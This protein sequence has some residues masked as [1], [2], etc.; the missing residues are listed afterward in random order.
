MSGVLEIVDANDYYPFGMNHLKTG[1]AFFGQ[2]SFKNFKFANKE[3]QEF[4]FY[5]FG[6]RLYMDDIV[7]WGVIDN[8]AEKYLSYS[9]YHY[10]GNNPISNFDIDG[11]EFTPEAWEYVKKL[12]AD[13]DN[14]QAKNNAEI[15]KY[16]AKI[17]GGGKERQIRSWERNVTNLQ[18]NNAELESARG[19]TAVL[20]GSN[21]M[22]DIRPDD[23]YSNKNESV[24]YTGFSFISGKIIIGLSKNAGMEL[25]SHELRHAYQFEIGELGF[26]TPELDKIGTQFL[27]DKTDEVDGYRRGSFFGGSTFGVNDLPEE[28]KNLPKGSINIKNNPQIIK[29]LSLPEGQREQALQRIANEGKVFRIGKKTY[30]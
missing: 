12:I 6:N 4:G 1:T 15:A 25:L 16:Q 22:Y 27:H 8:K 17:D 14:R 28:Y 26:I 10:A 3:L 2:S 29:A 30:K 21:Q 13:I 24:S 23:S 11:N 9:P 7:R 20:A 18:D 19:E 5:D